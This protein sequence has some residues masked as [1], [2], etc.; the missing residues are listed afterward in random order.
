MSD[1]GAAQVLIPE[2]RFWKLTGSFFGRLRR[3]LPVLLSFALGHGR[4]AVTRAIITNTG[5]WT[6]ADNTQRHGRS[7]RSKHLLQQVGSNTQGENSQT[8]KHKA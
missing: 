4:P 2:T 1:P 8:Q 7:V 6:Q 5:E 3:F